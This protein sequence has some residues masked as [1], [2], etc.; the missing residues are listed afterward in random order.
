MQSSDVELV[1]VLAD[2]VAKVLSSG[3]EIVKASDGD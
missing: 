3:I 2:T 1:N